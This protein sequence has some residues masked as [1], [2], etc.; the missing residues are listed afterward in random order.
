MRYLVFLLPLLAFTQTPDREKS[1]AAFQEALKVIRHPRC[2]NCHPSGDRP[3]QGIDMH[4]HIMNVQRGPDGHGKMGM[5]CQA[6]HGTANYEPS[7][8]P[9]APKWALAPR[10][11]AWQGLTDRELCVLFKDSHR[12]HMTMEQ[13][14]EHNEKDPLVGW[15]W[16]PGAGREPVPGTQA[17]FGALIREWVETGAA[18]PE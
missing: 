1:L 6:C 12:T 9:G 5:K 3:T 16:N 17:E 4:L 10:S 13:F 7:G 14:I 11:M 18:C 2:M 15:G 8:V